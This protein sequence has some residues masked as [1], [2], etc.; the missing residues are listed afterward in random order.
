[1]KLNRVV[2]TLGA[3]AAA[4]ASSVGAPRATQRRRLPAQ[5]V[6][7]RLLEWCGV[8]NGFREEQV[9]TAR[10]RPR[11]IRSHQPHRDPS[12]YRRRGQLS[13]IRDLI[14]KNVNAIVFNPNDPDALD[15]LSQSA[16]QGHRD[17]CS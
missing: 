17:C 4:A 14:A 16:R 9:C 8:G 10:R 3:L 1:M 15:R 13:D 2:R 11:C 5:D 12:Q 6:H 7:D